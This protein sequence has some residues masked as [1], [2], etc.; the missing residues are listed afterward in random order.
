MDNVKCVTTWNVVSRL[1][2]F[3]M[4]SC[5]TRDGIQATRQTGEDHTAGMTG[6]LVRAVRRAGLTHLAL[7]VDGNDHRVDEAVQQR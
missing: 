5:F 1:G 3:S 2:L 7:G 4:R 6:E